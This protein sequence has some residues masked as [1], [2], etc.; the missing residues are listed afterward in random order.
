MSSLKATVG[1]AAFRAPTT[2]FN[3]IERL[4][5]TARRRRAFRGIKRLHPRRV[6]VLCLG[7]ICRSPFAELA[8]KRTLVD[9][10][11]EVKSAGFIGPGRPSPAEAVEAAKTFG[12]D[13]AGHISALI[14]S[15]ILDGDELWMVMEPA[16]RR[17]LLAEVD[18]PRHRV[19]VLGDLD[20]EPIEQR[21]IPDPYG[22]PHEEFVACYLRIDRCIQVLSGALRRTTGSGQ[23]PAALLSDDPQVRRSGRSG[24]TTSTRSPA[25]PRRT[26]GDRVVP[27]LHRQA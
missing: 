24:R 1:R 23:P 19:F 18:V 14:S 13:L 10:T 9:K 4:A 8:L 20:P 15:E 27:S 2:A 7:N 25:D 5:H 6:L 26:H 3:L 12:L 22:R 11:I 16:H 17:R 21:A